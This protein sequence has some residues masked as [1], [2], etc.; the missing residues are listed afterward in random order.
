MV[1]WNITEKNLNWIF[2]V[3]IWTGDEQAVSLLIQNGANVNAM[4]DGETALHVAVAAGNSINIWYW[5]P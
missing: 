5:L 1:I 4:I 2:Y 3:F